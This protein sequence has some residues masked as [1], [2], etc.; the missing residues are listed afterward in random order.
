VSSSIFAGQAIVGAVL[1]WVFSVAFCPK[2][3]ALITGPGDSSAD[4]S[5]TCIDSFEFGAVPFAASLQIH[6]II[7]LSS[8]DA[9][10]AVVEERRWR[11][12]VVVVRIVGVGVVRVRGD[13]G[14]HDGCRGAKSRH[15]YAGRTVGA[16]YASFVEAATM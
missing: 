5:I 14:Q 1:T 6:S 3:V 10:S 8:L 7:H 4:S 12:G 13:S 15:Y 9:I 11:L 2:R 16:S